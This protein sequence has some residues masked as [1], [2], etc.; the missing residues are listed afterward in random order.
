MN[1]LVDEALKHQLWKHQALPREV[2]DRHSRALDAEDEQRSHDA[3]ATTGGFNDDFFDAAPPAPPEPLM[4]TEFLKEHKERFPKD[5]AFW[6]LHPD[7]PLLPP[8]HAIMTDLC[9]LS[10]YDRDKVHLLTPRTYFAGGGSLHGAAPHLSSGNIMVD[11]PLA[12]VTLGVSMAASEDCEALGLRT[13]HLSL[14]IAEVAQVMLL[15][16][17]R[18][19]YAGALGTHDPD[20]TASVVDTINRYVEAA[21]L[22]QH[23]RYG[24]NTPADQGIHPGRMFLLTPPCTVL[25]SKEAIAELRAVSTRSCSTGEIRVLTEDGNDIR[26][27]EALPWSERS[28]ADTAKALRAIRRALPHH[29]DAR[30]I[31][32]GKT[33]AKSSRH[34]DGYSGALPGIVEEALY[35]VRAGQPLYVAG[36]FGGAAAVLAQ[37]LGLADKLPIN[38]ETREAFIAHSPARDTVEEILQ[39]FDRD[40]TG[41]GAEDLRALASTRRPCDV[42]GLV[43]KGMTKRRAFEGAKEDR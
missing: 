40:S 24:A 20:L 38:A 3:T 43:I 6:L 26:L 22:E 4:L 14:V 17:G 18:I 23:R 31:I 10:G 37:E 42:A 35:T 39:L 36:G 34:P 13:K 5:T 7:P 12:G 41:L 27:S 2:A 32:G 30:L 1:R 11:R 28:A 15:A 16:G 9:A 33:R 8:E 29:C 25:T 21:K 19:T